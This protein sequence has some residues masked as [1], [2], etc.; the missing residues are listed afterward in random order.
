MDE[1]ED[2]TEKIQK[3]K[4][5]TKNYESEINKNE[6]RIEEYTNLCKDLDKRIE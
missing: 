3:A 4:E 2:L 1:I 5:D 6:H